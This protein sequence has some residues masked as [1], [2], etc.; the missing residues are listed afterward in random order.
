M[1]MKVGILTFYFNNDNFGGQ[2]QARALVKA[3]N[4]CDCMEAEQIQYDNLHSWQKLSYKKRF[5]KSLIYSFS[6]GLNNGFAFIFSRLNSQKALKNNKQLYKNVQNK[7]NGRKKVF[8]NFYLETPHSKAV[9]DNDSISQC[10]KN[11]DCIICGG[12]Q[13]WNDW[14]DWFVYNALDI[15]CLKFVPESIQK[16]SY[17]PSVPLS[18]VRPIF[19]NRLSENLKQL[20]AISVREKSSVQILEKK[21]KKRVEVVVDPVLLLTKEQWAMEMHEVKIDDKYVFCYLLGESIENRNAVKEFASRINC[22]LLTLPHII[23]INEED[24]YF[25]DIQDYTSGPAEFLS[26]IKNADVIVTD[27][28]HA[29]VFSMI[30]NKPFYVLERTTKVSGGSMGSRLADFLSEY[31]LISQKIEVDKLEE[32]CQIPNIDYSYSE[33]VLKQR[34]KDSYEFLKKN[35]KQK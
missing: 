20:D 5:V 14:N 2:L 8:K 15:Y 22:K 18:K 11:Y 24:R 21:T 35:L 25:G 4:M 26:L 31:G 13:I 12:D 27:S 7:I 34:R 23:D 6:G 16:F 33:A 32:V 9:F 17:A 28:F 30:F 3:V 10:L 19:I 29:A 1:K